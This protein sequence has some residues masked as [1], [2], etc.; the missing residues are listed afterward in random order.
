M[1]GFAPEVAKAGSWLTEPALDRSLRLEQ[2][3]C[4]PR[5]QEGSELK[6]VRTDSRH[7]MC[8]IR[9]VLQSFDLLSSKNWDIPAPSAVAPKSID[10]FLKVTSCPWRLLSATCSIRSDRLSEPVIHGVGFWPGF[11][12]VAGDIHRQ[13]QAAPYA[14]FVEG[15]TQVVLNDLLG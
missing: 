15:A 4:R 2:F 10:D 1:A 13:F 6:A 7:L 11:A 5:V 14:E 3:Q 12:A 9:K 8:T